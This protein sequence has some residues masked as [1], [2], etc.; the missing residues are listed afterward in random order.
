MLGH[1]FL[2]SSAKKCKWAKRF[3]QHIKSYKKTGVRLREAQL[4][5]PTGELIAQDGEEIMTLNDVLMLR[6]II[7]YEPGCTDVLYLDNLYYCVKL[8]TDQLI[9]LFNGS[10]YVITCVT[11]TEHTLVVAI[12]ARKLDS[13]R[14][15][16]WILA[17]AARL[18]EK[19]R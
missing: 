5:S 14:T 18:Q 1:L 11:E 3:L 7:L 2:S 6:D 10:N 13:D 17:V 15:I 12:N 19:Y 9:V 8:L 16:A 4:I